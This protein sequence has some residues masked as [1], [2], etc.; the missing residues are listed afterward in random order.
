[1]V[2][3]D[4]LNLV[5]G[6]VFAW[7]LLS[8]AVSAIND[9]LAGLFRIRAKHLWRNLAR[10]FDG[11][12]ATPSRLRDWAWSIPLGRADHRPHVQ[13]HVPSA[14]TS[15][16]ARSKGEPAGG[17]EVQ[18]NLTGLHRALQE[19]MPE[20]APDAWRTR[21]AHVPGEL[22][23]GALVQLAGQTR[24]ALLRAVDE[25]DPLHV[26]IEAS[27]LPESGLITREQIA[28]FRDALE[29]PLQQELDTVCDA[30]RR[31]ITV[32]DVV[33]LVQSNP[34][35]AGRL[36]ALGEDAATSL[37]TIQGEIERWF[38]GQMDA[39]TRFYRRQNRKIALVVSIVL[40]LV[41]QGDT[42]RQINDLRRDQNLRAVVASGA[43]GF[44]SDLPEADADV[45]Q[46][47]CDQVLA[48]DTPA[49]AE[50]APPTTGALTA[51]EAL[52]RFSERTECAGNL[53]EEARPLLLPAPSAIWTE[54]RQEGDPDRYEAGDMWR[55]LTHRLPGRIITV[56]ALL[57]GAQFWYDVLRRL[58]GLRST[59]KGR[60]AAA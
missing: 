13:D 10:L 33:E 31:S 40:V 45:L 52:R 36:R 58:V 42:I 30:A 32:G 44:V 6:V 18:R 14:T 28:T 24:G 47:A 4:L 49:G 39:L 3:S 41:V 5:I 37:S 51:E 43:V 59:P 20:P 23:A 21:I 11:T 57:F 19:T 55:W 35:L 29:P 22:L 50:A 2:D 54:M 8:V 34:A 9:G 27:E 7:F 48:G 46:A 53:L 25:T 1:M 56:V 16:R 12:I 38:D 60:P 17:E 15:L 26:A